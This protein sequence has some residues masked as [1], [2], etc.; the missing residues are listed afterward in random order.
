MERLVWVAG[1]VEEIIAT[2]GDRQGRRDVEGMDAVAD[3]DTEEEA[4]GGG[5]YPGRKYG[6]SRGFSPRNGQTATF[7]GKESQSRELCF[8]LPHEA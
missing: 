4:E 2:F 1:L 7:H 8:M 3:E 6:W 5:G